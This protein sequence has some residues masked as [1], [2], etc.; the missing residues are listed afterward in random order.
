MEISMSGFENNL[1]EGNVAK[2]L[3]RFSLPFILSNIVQSFYAVADMVIVGHFS[4][5]N[6]MSG[7]NIGGQ[8]TFLVTNAV[9]GLSVGATVLIGQY[10]GSGK[11][12]EIK[13]TIGTLFSTL[14][15]LA[16][17]ITAGMLFL[18]EPL[19]KLINTPAES[20]A[21]SKSYFN[22]TLLGTV[23]IF[24]YNALSAIMRGMG[25]SKNPLKFVTIACF[26][27][28][29]LDFIL[30]KYYNMGATGAAIATVF[31]QAI[32]VILCVLYLKKNG[33]IFDFAISSLKFHSE[34][35]KM[36]LK[37]GIPTMLNNITV[38]ISFL[39]LT[40]FVNNLGVTASAAVGAVGKF[41]S[42]AILPAIAMSSAI[43]AMSA[44]NFGA[45]KTDRAVKT[46]KTGLV[47]AIAISYSIFVLTQLFP[48]VFLRVFNNEPEL[49]ETG[50][51]YLRVFSF[52]YLFVPVIFCLNGLFIG[53]GHTTFSL[54]NSIISSLAVRIP[55]AYIFGTVLGKG[56]SGFALGAPFASGIALVIAIIFF[57]SGRWKKRVIASTIE[58]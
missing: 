27:N 10:L 20:F 50:V 19:L 31:S 46:M 25:D 36:L 11:K 17:V 18:N 33:F 37:I 5:A 43:S 1:T 3:I 16:V 49:V 58:L 29:V 13:E 40:S 54:F 48:E 41:N 4:N 28:I 57:F 7:V 26:V 30:V 55:A 39:F 6:N 42:F 9:I 44:Q 22:I 32:S 34:R 8:V 56:L 51:T 52:D 24:A 21:E 53:A 15:V 47:I 23:F 35:L 2:Q 45:G 38:S 12:N 14:L